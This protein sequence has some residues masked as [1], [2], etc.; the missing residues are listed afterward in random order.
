MNL[1]LLEANQDNRLGRAG[2]TLQQ[3]TNLSTTNWIAATNE[4]GVLGTNKFIIV[5]P[6]V[7]NRYYRLFKP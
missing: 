3:H 5:D 6:P 4:I 1:S 7:G 2:F